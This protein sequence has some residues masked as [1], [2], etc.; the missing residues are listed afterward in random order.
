MQRDSSRR[1]FLKNSGPDCRGLGPGGRGR[2][3]TSTLRRTTPSNWPWWAAAAAEPGR[4][5]TPWRPR[6]DPS[7]WWRWPTSS[8]TAAE[9]LPS[10]EEAVRPGEGSPDS[11][12]AASTPPGRCAAR[13]PVPRLRRLPEGH[14]LSP[15][16]R[17]RDPRHALR[18]PLGP[19]WPG[20]REGPE[21]FHGKADH[22]RR[23]RHAQDAR[24]GRESA[25]K[26]QGGRGPDV[27]PLQGPLGTARSDPRRPDRRY[28]SC[29]LSPGRARRV[30]RSQAGAISA[31]CSTR[32]SST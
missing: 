26:P 3:G 9:Q 28:R 22:R 5:P 17:R 8:S 18:L 2:A 16:G 32:F 19:L 6:A 14:G 24:P 12:S 11:R 7:S 13:P 25:R 10:S 29:G 27:P 1:E 4:R 21:R 23:P 30:H 20:H 31:S 15:A